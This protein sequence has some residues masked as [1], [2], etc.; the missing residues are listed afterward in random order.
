MNIKTPRMIPNL[1]NHESHE[2]QSADSL[3][4]Q[5]SK[6]AAKPFIGSMLHVSIFGN[7]KIWISSE[8]RRL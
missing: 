3:F 4:R 5:F 1:T 7:L 8:Q 2:S 6:S